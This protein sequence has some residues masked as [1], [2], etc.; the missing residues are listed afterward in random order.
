MQSNIR[1]DE[2]RPC[3]EGRI[4]CFDMESIDLIPGL[5]YDD[6]TCMHIIVAK[7]MLT[8]E[9]F[10]FFDPFELRDPDNREWLEME[11]EQDGDLEE[12]I[13]FLKAADCLIQQ[14][15]SGFDF[16]AFEKVWPKLWQY[17]YMQRRDASSLQA[18]RF[19]NKVMDTYVMSCTLNPERKLPGQAF[20]VGKGNIGPHSIEAHGLR[21]GRW[22]PENEDWSKLTDHM[23]HR[24]CEDVEIG[25]DFYNFLWKEWREQA[26]RPNK[27]TGLSIGTAYRLELQVAFAMAR[28]AN[29]GFRFDIHKALARCEELDQQIQDTEIAF[30][31]HMPQRLK[32]SKLSPKQKEA[33]AL[34]EYGEDFL[35]FSPKEKAGAL[36]E[37]PEHGSELTTVVDVT[38]KNGEYK[39]AVTKHYPKAR[40]FMADH[41]RSFV[42]HTGDFSEEPYIGGDFTP[43]RFEDIPLGNRDAV[44]QVL[45]EHGWLGITYNDSEQE[46][47]DTGRED[48]L[49]PWAGKIDEK[50]LEAWKERMP[51]PEWCEGIAA[52]YVLNSRRNQILNPKDMAYFTENGRW[53]KQQNGKEECRGILPR[54]RNKVTGE[55]AQAYFQREGRWPEEGDWR[56]PAVAF[57]AAT[58]TFRMRHR[59]VVNIPSRGL[60]PLRD[61]F[62]ASDG[63]LVLGCDG[64]GLELRMLAHFMA[65]SVYQEVV[66][67]GDIHSHNQALAGLP[68]RDMAKTFIYAFL[69]GSGVSNLAKVCGLSI[70]EMEARIARFKRELPALASLV[71]RIQKAGEAAGHLLAVDGRWG[72]IR[73]KDGKLLVHTMLNVLLQM[74]G[75]L[76]MK[77]GLAFAEREMLKEQ[78][79][80]DEAGHPAFVVNM[81]DEIQMEVP[82]DEVLTYTYQMH[83]DEWKAEEKRVHIDEQGRMWSAPHK[84]SAGE[85]TINVTR[86]YHRAGEILAQQMTR[87]GEFLKMRCPLAGEY[88]VG[89]SWAATH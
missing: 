37:Q 63:K 17:D 51:V 56:A 57:F 84:E 83:K 5:R 2:E 20:G 15:G 87:A 59:I 16:L 50:S 82:E 47:I 77:Y 31:P 55:E 9:V 32:K 52:W 11:G 36:A 72:R 18:E 38:K 33:L 88:K 26:A 35:L 22:K 6:R 19:P 3:G 12:G 53:P 68:T 89:T 71:E 58:N 13:L 78:I 66:L 1:P 10:I 39:A 54:C 34:M 61:L 43:I 76:C 42:S 28:Q 74:T 62:I 70:P 81:H 25:A 45:Y 30:R 29:R 41:T 4:L 44:K 85:D 48:E 46:L 65:D 21:M 24:C 7:D 67:N 75:S 49:N 64:A 8:G 80:L 73:A 14:N 40:G 69:Y 60:Y 86:Q 23:I 27:Y 79:G